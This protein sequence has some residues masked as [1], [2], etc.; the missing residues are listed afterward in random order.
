MQLWS[1]LTIE[2]IN[3]FI[4]SKTDIASSTNAESTG[5]LTSGFS[6]IVLA[7]L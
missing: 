6:G 2:C 1:N 7:L 3:F 5:A 4:L